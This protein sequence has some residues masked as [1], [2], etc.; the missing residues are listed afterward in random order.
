MGTL[1]AS[2]SIKGA[3]AN[4]TILYC[5]NGTLSVCA[6]PGRPLVANLVNPE[7]EINFEVPEPPSND[8]GGWGLTLVAG[9]AGPSR[10]KKRPTAAA[11]KG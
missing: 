4:Y 8:L 2:C 5:T 3:E 10:A 9:S 1:S 7:C 6:Y 11:S